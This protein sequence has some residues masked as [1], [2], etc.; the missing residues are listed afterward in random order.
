VSVESFRS[1][2]YESMTE[3]PAPELLEALEHA[4][5]PAEPFL[6]DGLPWPP[7]PPESGGLP[8]RLEWLAER[9]GSKRHLAELAGISESQ[10]Y[11]YFEPDAAIPHDKLIAL[12]H[13]AVAN[14]SWLLSGLGDPAKPKERLR[15]PFRKDLM[16]ELEQGFSQLMAEYQTPIPLPLR[17]RMVAYLYEV[18]RHEE[19]LT[20]TY[21]KID[22]FRLLQYVSFMAEMKSEA[23]MDVLHEAFHLLTYR[24]LT[25]KTKDHHQLLT[26]WCN[27]LVRGMRGY[28]NSYAGQ[29]YFD[30]MGLTL[31]TEAVAELHHFVTQAYKIIGKSHLDWLDAGCGN[32]RHLAHLY[33]H[34]PNLRI[35][36]LELSDL[37]VE[38]CKKLEKSER[39]PEDCVQ[40]G[41]IRLAPF[42]SESFDVVFARLSLHSLPFLDSSMHIGI[43][44]YLDEIYRILRPKGILQWITLGGDHFDFFMMWQ[45]LSNEDIHTLAKSSRFK[46]IEFKEIARDDYFN[47]KSQIA[48]RSKTAS[49]KV[50]S[51]TFQKID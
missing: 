21:A 28:Y 32:G 1:L 19:Y 20:K 25:E 7:L 5:E 35:K 50:L 24:T 46:I 43:G 44:E 31:P 17:S 10:L 36:G 18:L 9:L 4:P 33:R 47:K 14:P 3:T 12:A 42:K 16:I 6:V 8:E 40:Q 11:R 13:A 22:K 2:I 51:I 30:R 48:V 37:G 34:V 27:L 29:V 26:T 49:N 23:E 45:Y 39:L 38:L 15:P 41:D